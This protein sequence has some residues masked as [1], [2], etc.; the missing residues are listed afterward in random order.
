MGAGCA[1]TDQSAPDTGVS[2]DASLH[3]DGSKGAGD[4]GPTPGADGGDVSSG[5][6]EAGGDTS[7]SESGAE[8]G[9]SSCASLPLCD[10]FNQDTAGA[11]PPGPTWSL[12]LGCDA[13]MTM[14]GP[15][16]AGGLLVQ[17]DSSEH[18]S[19]KNSLRVVGG[20]SCGYYVVN[21][22]ALSS[23]GT[24]VYA[25]FWVMFSGPPTT[26]H[27]GY[28]SMYSG[29]ELS[30]AVADY[31]NTPQLRLGFQGGVVVWNS[32]ID[33]SDSTL[34]DID[35]TGEMA[36]VVPVAS[37][38]SCMEL[39]LDQTNAN[40]ELRFEGASAEATVPG[41]SYDGTA[42]PGVSDTWKSSGPT[43]LALKSFGLGWLGLNDQYTVWFDDVAL[44]GTGWIGCD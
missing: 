1:A 25:R 22:S 28:V 44:S 2:D 19:G 38:W 8:G 13:A 41:L 12:V 34:P 26:G 18:H 10:N 27:N 11:A 42:T 29:P 35:S 31:D 17:V 15:A 37:A 3:P 43:S 14:N 24:D 40:I 39:H 9:G 23:L 4:G 20:D 36:S 32:T 30:S 6:P 16:A 33:G 21:T 5:G 7:A